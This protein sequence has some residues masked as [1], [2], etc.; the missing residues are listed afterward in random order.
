MGRMLAEVT[1]C[2]LDHSDLDE[3]N[4]IGVV[5]TRL[6]IPIRAVDTEAL[7]KAQQVLVENPT[8]VWNESKAYRGYEGGSPVPPGTKVVD[9][10]WI[11]SASIVSVEL[12][13]R[14]ERNLD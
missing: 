4:E 14:R 10:E 12:Q 6:P 11:Q 3:S 2:V 7:R 1:R 5:G 8:P 13:R 9:S